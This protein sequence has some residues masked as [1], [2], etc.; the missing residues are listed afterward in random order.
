LLDSCQLVSVV[1][2]QIKHHYQLCITIITVIG[3]AAR[4]GWQCS[5]VYLCKKICVKMCCLPV[6][7]IR[8]SQAALPDMPVPQAVNKIIIDE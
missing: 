7:V 3:V 5:F 4:R 8:H 2:I 1:I 6:L